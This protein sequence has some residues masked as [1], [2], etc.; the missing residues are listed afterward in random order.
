MHGW[1]Y[2]SSTDA[3][4][5][6]VIR[7]DDAPLDWRHRIRERH[8]DP[9][10]AIMPPQHDWQQLVN[11]RPH[12]VIAYQADAPA[13]SLA[14]VLGG[15]NPDGCLRGIVSYLRTLPEWWRL[16]SPP[17]FALAAEVIIYADGKAQLLGLPRCPLPGTFTV[18]D[19]P[20]RVFYLAPEL[21]RSAIDGTRNA[22]AWEAVD[23]YTIGAIALQGLCRLP[24]IQRVE[25]ALFR[26]A[27]GSLL[28]Q[29]TAKNNLPPWLHGVTQYRQTLSLIRRLTSTSVDTRLAV[30]LPQ[31]ADRFDRL[32]ELLDPRVAAASLRDRTQPREALDLLQQVF[33]LAETLGI[34]AEC[35]YDL[36]CFA[37][38]LCAQYLHRP[39]E[40][41]DYFERAIDLNPAVATAYR[42]QLR[43][44]ATAGYQREL[45]SLLESSRTI[46]I[47]GDTKLWRNYRFLAGSRAFH[48]GDEI[49]Q[50]DDRLVARYA[51]WRRQ[52]EVARD[53]IYPRL[54]D[55]NKVY[56]WWD[57]DLN[58]AYVQAFLGLETGNGSNL[59]RAA[60]QLQ[61]IKDGMKH[62]ASSQSF[63][64]AA[65]QKFGQEVTQLEQRIH[66]MKHNADGTS[67]AATQMGQPHEPTG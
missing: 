55:A 35:Q 23:R 13:R 56:I 40:A 24:E 42:E 61:Q 60:E 39:L 22:S 3:T 67:S 50:T 8:S 66:R 18:F 44:I 27:G 62:V 28:K 49:S 1:V 6:R 59:A 33:P 17:L 54:Y 37:G 53:F 52:Y 30:D 64:P 12:L 34:D 29:P 45:A 51:L 41:V 48:A 26:A 31:L 57:F 47:E 58:L 25:R 21:V 32:R 43:A 19:E 7:M 9:N 10:Q 14:E 63:Q 38:E 65:L 2:R 16:I 11:G 15:G 46:A 4:W 5:Y 36:M 20:R